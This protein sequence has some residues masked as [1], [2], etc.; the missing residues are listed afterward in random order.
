MSGGPGGAGDLSSLSMVLPPPGFAVSFAAY[1][2]TQEIP[3]NATVFGKRDGPN[4]ALRMSEFK[5]KMKYVFAYNTQIPCIYKVTN[6][7]TA[8]AHFFDELYLSYLLL[9]GTQ[10]HK[11]NGPGEF[12]NVVFD[13][14]THYANFKN[15]VIK[16]N[17]TGDGPRGFPRDLG[18]IPELVETWLKM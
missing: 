3:T 14:A 6:N 16:P 13:P 2:N 7:S 9:Y 4:G 11:Y 17:L 1:S 18:V 8:A 12:N 5:A 10:I 15:F